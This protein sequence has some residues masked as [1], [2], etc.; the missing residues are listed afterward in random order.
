MQLVRMLFVAIVGVLGFNVEG[1]QP[2]ASVQTC[3]DL[4]ADTPGLMSDKQTQKVCGGDKECVHI[5]VPKSEAEGAYHDSK[6]KPL[7]AKERVDY[8]TSKKGNIYFPADGTQPTTEEAVKYSCANVEDD[9]ITDWYMKM[10][11]VIDKNGGNSVS[12]DD[13][14]KAGWDNPTGAIPDEK[15]I[16]TFDA[17]VDS[18]LA[19]DPNDPR[20]SRRNLFKRE[21]CKIASNPVG[22]VLLYRILIE[23]RRHIIG[24]IG[25][26]ED[27]ANIEI[28][29]TVGSLSN[30]LENCPDFFES[31]D[32]M[33]NLKIL[34]DKD[35]F[36]FRPILP[37][38]NGGALLFNATSI[39]KQ[40]I[41]GKLPNY[42]GVLVRQQQGIWTDDLF[43][44]FIHW[45]HSLRDTLRMSNDLNSEGLF[46]LYERIGSVY[47]PWTKIVSDQQR[48][49]AAVPWHS[50]YDRIISVNF[51][52]MRTI[53]GTDSSCPKY[54]EG[55]DIS[56]NLFALSRSYAIG[57]LL[58]MIRFGH[59][60]FSYVEHAHSVERT[61]KTLEVI[62]NY[63]ITASYTLPVTPLPNA[64]D[65]KGYSVTQYPKEIKQIADEITS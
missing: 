4:P 56:E 60:D 19:D 43:H 31:R 3:F 57:S 44:E 5:I 1:M 9:A 2:Q 48:K 8:A 49:L 41:V 37:D 58:C 65:L 24:N 59:K 20:I 30:L 61:I 21:F 12:D 18:T 34:W 10:F 42:G 36:A 29:Q 39:R 23:I 54:L 53:L 63:G 32:K 47:Y 46:K 16:I 26:C 62:N 14:V 50:R 7:N 17:S 52:E 55:D 25:V 28:L 11:G 64:F 33:R 35:V 51:E 45:Y 38:I 15:R 22:R 6:L 13:Y 27:N 40:I